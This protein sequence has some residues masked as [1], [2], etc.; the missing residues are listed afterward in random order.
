MEEIE[1]VETK[2]P[3]GFG[4]CEYDKADHVR[5]ALRLLNG[6]KIGPNELLLKVDSKTQAYL[7]DFIKRKKEMLVAA[8]SVTLTPAN[9]AEVDIKL[10]DTE[11]QFEK[12]E[13]EEDENLKSQLLAYYDEN[14]VA[15]GAITMIERLN[16][17]LPPPPPPPLFGAQGR[18]PSRQAGQ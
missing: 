10:G 16:A 1:D 17:P 8:K 9:L 12:D 3:K 2:K 4:F 11:E 6:F 7:D 15:T 5:R 14:L 13:A 18:R